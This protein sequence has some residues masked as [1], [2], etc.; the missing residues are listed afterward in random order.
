MTSARL[1]QVFG[2]IDEANSHDPTILNDGGMSGPAELI[3]GQRSSAMLG[4]YD[5]GASE[6]LS[7]AGR[8]WNGCYFGS[9]S[10]VLQGIEC[11]GRIIALPLHQIGVVAR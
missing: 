10:A 6:L 7:V 2:L 9:Q 8:K 1:Q 5:T 11:F 3:Y 4:R